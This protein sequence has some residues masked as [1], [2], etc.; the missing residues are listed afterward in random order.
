MTKGDGRSKSSGA[1]QQKIWKPGE[2][3]IT[4][5]EQHDEMDDQ[6]QNKVWEPSI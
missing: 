4:K 2:L 3:N 1:L 6:L 5:T